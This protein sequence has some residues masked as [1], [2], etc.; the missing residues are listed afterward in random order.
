MKKSLFLIISLV[1]SV[2][3]I[4]PTSKTAFQP[5]PEILDS[6]DINPQADYDYYEFR[7]GPSSKRVFISRLKNNA[8][9]ELQTKLSKKFDSIS[10]DSGFS[11]FPHLRGFHYVLSY[12]N[13]KVEIWNSISKLKKFLG[14]IDTET[15]AQIY[16]MALG[17]PPME[18]DT[19]Q[20]G[21]K[22]ENDLFIVRATKMDQLCAPIVENRYTFSIQQNGIID[23]LEIKEVHRDSK[24]CI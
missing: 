7:I 6:L 20:T 3:C 12:R 14:N 19:A 18:N 2:S 15:E 10:I 11:K 13:E 17:Y 1:I 5:F 16:I 8:N 24:G 9:T 21:V 22:K 23:T 4:R